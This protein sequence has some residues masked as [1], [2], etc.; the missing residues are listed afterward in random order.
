MIF[1]VF[2]LLV[3]LVL[4]VKG[5]D[6]FVDASV[7]MAEISGIPK[8]IIGATVVS[9]ATTLPELLVSSIATVQGNLGIAAGNAIGS[10]TANVGLIMGISIVCLPSVIK[11]KDLLA[12]GTILLVSVAA[13][14]L[15]AQQGQLGILQSFTLLLMFAVFMFENVRAAKHADMLVLEGESK[16]EISKKEISTNVFKF[17]AGIIGIVVGAQLMVEYGSELARVL[18]VPESIIGVTIIAIGTSLPELVTTITAISKKQASLSIGNIIG[19]NIIDITVILPVCALISGG[20]VQIL[21]QTARLD[22]PVC[23][24]ICAMAVVPAIFRERFTRVQGVL[25]MVC[26]AVYVVVLS[27]GVLAF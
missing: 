14:M 15:F 23:L 11:R 7:W 4:I 20:T 27:S 24:A 16:R 10:V 25:L 1:I 8:F 17:I 18:G 5:G 21:E 6:I 2:M 3:S 9:F 13:L 26:Y 12:K 19:A 22:L